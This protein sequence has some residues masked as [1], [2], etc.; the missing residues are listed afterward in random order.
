VG[1]VFERVERQ[2]VTCV[3]APR[4]T[5]LR[6]ALAA[7]ALLCALG[8]PKPGLAQGADRFVL[9]NTLSPEAALALGEVYAVR[10]S[11]H[12]SEA[13]QAALR[14]RAPQLIAKLGVTLMDERIGG[15]PVVRIAP[16]NCRDA[17]R[18]FIYLHGGGYTA[19]S[20]RALIFLPALLAVETGTQV[21]SIDYTLAPKGK[22][23]DVTAEVVAV[24]RG[25]LARHIQPESAALFG[26][27]AGGGLAA[28]ATLRFRDEG[29]PLPGALYLVSPWSDISG[30]GDTYQTLSPMDPLLNPA[31][32][33]AAA[34]A[35]AAPKDQRNPYVSPVYG[36]F[37]K[38]FPPTLIQCGTREI[39]L[40][41]C[42]RLY[43]AI[44]AGG[45]EAV[46]DVYEGMPHAFPAYASDTPETRTAVAR[47]ASFL[48]GN[49]RADGATVRH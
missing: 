2:G 4:Q 47:A 19:G 18:T 30:R 3:A 29:L 44:R 23:K 5:R 10:A 21:I 25:L 39:F 46:L 43:Q 14:A 37:S 12:P 26:D 38:P 24:W 16:P 13:A 45:H 9:P 35:Y 31:T 34:D 41:N 48:R 28:G 8:L 20:T 27:S 6:V 36:D 15:V 17:S 49:L 22:W 42:V 40:S 11:P 1:E 7:L 32:L 33:K